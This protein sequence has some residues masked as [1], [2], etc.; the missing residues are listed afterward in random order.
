MAAGDVGVLGYYTQARIL[1]TVGL[2]S[3]E[4]LDYYPVPE[5]M[6]AGMAYAIPPDL[7]FDQQ[8][9]Y[10]VFPEIYI[11]NGLLK[12][13]RFADQYTLLEKIETDIYDSDGMLIYVRRP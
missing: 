4:P 5:E 10:L 6:I 11:R 1:D 9:D 2:N 8:P 7:I 3:V 13:P 12:D